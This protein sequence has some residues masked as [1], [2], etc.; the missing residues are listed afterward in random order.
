M[1]KVLFV[2]SRENTNMDNDSY[3]RLGILLMGTLLKNLGHE[4]RIVHSISDK[5]DVFKFRDLL[6]EYQ[7][8][9]VGFT[10]TTFQVKWTKVL[11]EEVKRWNKSCKVVI[12][13]PHPSAVKEEIF[14]DFSFIDYSVIGE[15]EPLIK[16]LLEGNVKGG[17]I[18]R[19][20][21]VEDLDS[22]PFPDLS[23]V[24]VFNFAGPYPIGKLPS[25][26]IM[27]SRGC[28]QNCTFCFKYSYS[29]KV[30]Y[31]SVNYVLE[32]IEYYKKLG[33]KEIGFLDD[34]LNLNQNWLRSLLEGIRRRGLN[35]GIIYRGAFRTDEKL[36]SLDLLKDMKRSGFW[37]L[38]YG[39]E[40]GSQKIL[41]NMNKQVRVEDT[42]RA[43]ELTHRVGIKTVAPFMIGIPGETRDTIKESI[44]FSKKLKA[45]SV[46]FTR[47]QPLP[48]TVFRDQ[49]VKAGYILN[50]DY[51][52]YSFTQ[53]NVRTD[54]LSFEELERE[55]S[56]VS[57][58]TLK[59]QFNQC[60][61]D[62]SLLFRTFKAVGIRE[63]IGRVKRNLVKVT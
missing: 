35:K 30:R 5:V 10:L 14:K 57:K 58:L 56:K 42:R 18:D 25:I 62:P 28:P 33:I 3:P 43:F 37:L 2:S 4:V 54:K 22:L 53:T 1:S 27:G 21:V 45:F 48:G 60:L 41:D 29:R 11:T 50:R 40:S 59:S 6:K 16:F 15:G 63:V 55:F 20:E 23:L 24:D 9:I 47:A 26:Q 49:V 51:S 17:I 12:G 46:G 31:H 34:T 52:D 32:L 44:E 36:V 13:G 8:N 19:K 38:F 61:E 39:V 7:P